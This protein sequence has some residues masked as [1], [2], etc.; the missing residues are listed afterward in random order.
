M[1]TAYNEPTMGF[2]SPLDVLKEGIARAGAGL[3]DKDAVQ[4]AVNQYTTGKKVVVF[5]WTRRVF[6][7]SGLGDGNMLRSL[8]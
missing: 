4:Q 1:V 7:R 5:S 3:Y 2:K 8:F 6:V